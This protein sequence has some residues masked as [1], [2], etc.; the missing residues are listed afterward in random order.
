MQIY[1]GN[2]WG[3]V[4]NSSSFTAQDGAVVCRSLGFDSY[5]GLA[6]CSSTLGGNIPVWRNR[7]SCGV[8]TKHIRDCQ[9]MFDSHECVGHSSDI[10]VEC[11][12]MYEC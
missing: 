6:D 9:T 2:T 12:G 1:H 5:T 4:C 8:N 10:G 7:L 3:S 11:E